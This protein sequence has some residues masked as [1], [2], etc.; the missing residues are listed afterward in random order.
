MSETI[1]TPENVKVLSKWN[2]IDRDTF[3]NRVRAVFESVAGMLKNTLGPAGSNTIIERFGDVHITKDGWN[4]LK[5]IQFSESIDNTIMQLLVNIAAQVVI[6]VGDGSTSSIVAANQLLKTIESDPVLSKIRPKDLIDSLTK[7]AERISVEIL[8][9][10]KKID[11]ETTEGLNEIYKLAF[12]STN[13]DDKIARM[14]REIYEKTKNPSIEYVKSRTNRTFFEIID[15]YQAPISYLDTIYINNSDDGTCEINNPLILMFDHRVDRENHF[16][17]VIQHVI[18]VAMQSGRRL[19]VIAPRYD[20][21]FLNYLRSTVQLE[22]KASRTTQVVYA[23][24][25]LVNNLQHEFYND[26]SIM[27][28]CRIFRENDM[29]ELLGLNEEDESEEGQENKKEKLFPLDDFVGEVK[30]ITIGPSVTTISGFVKRNEELYKVALTDAITKYKKAEETNMELNVPNPEVYDLKKRVS[31]L[32]GKMGVIHVGGNS[33]LEKGANFDLVEDAVRACESA[34]NYGYN[35]GGNLIIPIIIKDLIKET[36]EVEYEETIYT[37][38]SKAFRSVFSIVL[39]NGFEGTS[40]SDE[41]IM[42]IVDKCVEDQKVYNLITHQYSSD[43]INPC[44]TDIEITKAA[45]SIVALIMGSNQ[46][47]TIK[48]DTDIE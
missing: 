37:L 38:F 34:F 16:E 42:Q 39:K 27:A 8:K 13:G 43:V 4:I 35:I 40:L 24:A 41:E 31:K 15:G 47:L 26:F 23:R 33:S 32:A 22:V 1:A 18:Q 11:I 25:T 45:T 10:S 17:H 44:F 14:I 46:F 12:V 19:V 48:S 2:V 7:V 6:K 30:K 3:R 9:R 36:M 28:G 20:E 21:T 29:R 5:K